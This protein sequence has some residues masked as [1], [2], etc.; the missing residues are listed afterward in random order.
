[1][2]WDPEVAAALVAARRLYARTPDAALVHAVIQRET[3]HGL[4]PITGTREPNAPAFLGWSLRT[5]INL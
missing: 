5:G 4:L 1:M 2:K 3:L